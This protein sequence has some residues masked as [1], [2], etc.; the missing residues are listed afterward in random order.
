MATLSQKI[1]AFFDPTIAINDDGKL[2]HADGFFDS[3]SD[4]T[5]YLDYD[6]MSFVR[7]LFYDGVDNSGSNIY[8]EAFEDLSPSSSD[9][10]SDD[11]PYYGEILDRVESASAAQNEAA[12]NSA[13][14]AMEFEAEQAQLN[15]DFQ[16]AQA[17]K[18]MD[19]QTRMSNTAYQ[20]AMADLKAAG[21]NPKMVAQ[22]GGAST[23][24][25]VA[26]SGAQASG[27]AASMSMANTSALAGVLE[28]YITSANS[29]DRQNNGFVQN[30]ISLLLNAAIYGKLA[31][32]Y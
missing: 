7:S 26:G 19:Y 9:Q 12:Q 13:D 6:S 17:Q 24:S 2:V 1:A 29:L 27:H 16:A 4:S 23:P 3:G 20:R 32:I 18:A 11:V 30:I 14:R 28:T 5:D 15:R 22:L 31:G 8:L 10:I 25:G 21:I